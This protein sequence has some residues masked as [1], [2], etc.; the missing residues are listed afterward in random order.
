MLNS[1]TLLWKIIIKKITFY[2]FFSFLF[3]WFC[4]FITTVRKGQTTLQCMFPT[5]KVKNELSPN[6]TAV[7]LKIFNACEYSLRQVTPLQLGFYRIT[8]V[9]FR[10][11]HSMSP[12]KIFSAT[13]PILFM[14][15]LLSALW[16]AQCC[17]WN[18]H[19]ICTFPFSPCKGVVQT[20]KD[21]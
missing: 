1:T 11:F 20:I 7:W 16:K 21:C 10:I 12:A 8:F 19:Q 18:S 14:D 15:T 2:V 4:K 3:F 17:V 9:S 13:P 5:Y 6:S